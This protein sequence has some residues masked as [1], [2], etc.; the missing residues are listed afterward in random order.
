MDSV[1]DSG[2]DLIGDIT[3]GTHISHLYS[4]KN[5]FKKVMLPYLKAGL[6]N[7]ELCIWVFH[8]LNYQDAISVLKTVI[9]DVDR[10][11][12]K[13]QLIIMPH[14][15]MY[16]KDNGF[17]KERL[18]KVWFSFL[19]QAKENG[20]D[21]LRV[22]G[23]TAW[24]ESC[25]KQDFYL[26]EKNLESIVKGHPLIVL[27][28]YDI[29]SV[30]I[31]EVSDIINNHNFTI[32][33]DNNDLKL[34]KG[35]EFLIKEQQL[36]EKRRKLDEMLNSDNLKTEF[37]SNISHELRTPLNVMISA[38]S[39]I[40]KITTQ[41]GELYIEEA[42]KGKLKKYFKMIEQNCYRQLRL[43][44][45]L[46]D[47]TK[48]ESDFY[49][50]QLKNSNIVE[51]VENI[52]MSVAEY[53]ESKGINLVFD[54]N[55]EELYISCDPDQIERIILNLL[56]NAI[57]FTN[58]GGSIFVNI[59]AVNNKVE[60]NVR[61]TGI[62]IPSD[63]LEL[64]FDRFRQADHPNTRYKGSGI[65]LSLVKSLVEKHKGSIRVNSKEGIGTEFTIQLPCETI[66]EEKVAT[67]KNNAQS[68]IEK[69]NIEFSDIY[70]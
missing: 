40:K 37:F 31:P 41:C 14:T 47:I 51:V 24:L 20:Y 12:K 16:T 5:D 64:I 23:D 6:N 59:C 57:K 9:E 18:I 44:N 55:T 32:I 58:P 8:G 52:T 61:D 17:N 69:I 3:W 42:A 36:E 63:K 4:S 2:I 62:G 34:I 11:I 67:P 28:L 1:R 38:I 25:Y 48:I 10:Y 46:I 13:E 19:E 49:K 45:N 21:G 30:S 68:N 56:S 26:Y 53:I 50:L 15:D 7:N 22:T 65:G 35:M 27:C 66:P 60:I 70:S 54:T 39:L 29:N 43:I 33:S